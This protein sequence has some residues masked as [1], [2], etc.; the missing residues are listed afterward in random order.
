M[1]TIRKENKY[2]S[3]REWVLTCPA[4]QVDV[5]GYL[6]PDEPAFL[7]GVHNGLHHGH[8]PEAFAVAVDDVPVQA[9]AGVGGA[10]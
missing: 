5:G 2:G 6:E 9:V 7:A 10:V 4:C 3:A 8:R 1:T